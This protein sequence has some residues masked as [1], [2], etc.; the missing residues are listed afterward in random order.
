MWT[1]EYYAL[2][3]SQLQHGISSDSQ[4]FPVLS[5]VVSEDHISHVKHRIT[6]E[7]LMKLLVL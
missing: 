3:F 4:Y 7:A 1:P 5:S 6:L 2:L